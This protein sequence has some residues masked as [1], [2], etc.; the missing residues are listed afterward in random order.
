MGRV[1]HTALIKEHDVV[2]A[3]RASEAIELLAQGLQ[4]GTIA[5]CNTFKV[6]GAIPSSSGQY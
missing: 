1:I 6:G 5:A 3:E 4:Q 2:V